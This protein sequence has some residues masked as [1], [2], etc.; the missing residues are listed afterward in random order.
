MMLTNEPCDLTLSTAIEFVK[1]CFLNV[2]VTPPVPANNSKM[3][4][5]AA[6]KPD[7]ASSQ[8]LPVLGIS[9]LCATLN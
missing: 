1:P 5:F 6:V 4:V 8:S 2:A 9:S 7:K 3:I